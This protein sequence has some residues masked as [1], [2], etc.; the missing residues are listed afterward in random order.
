MKLTELQFDSV[1][2]S[3]KLA[4]IVQSRLA[5]R[6]RMMFH[7]APRLPLNATPEQ[8]EAYNLA[9][10]QYAIDSKIEAFAKRYFPLISD[11]QSLEK[12]IFV[13][14]L[15]DFDYSGIEGLTGDELVNVLAAANYQNNNIFDMIINESFHVVTFPPTKVIVEP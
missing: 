6:V 8:V 5:N 11:W 3:A 7:N 15:N 14:A 10:D 9:V 2:R 4:T 1:L 12:R 13:L